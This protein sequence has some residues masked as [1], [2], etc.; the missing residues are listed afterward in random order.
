MVMDHLRYLESQC[1]KWATKSDASML[2]SD[3][4]D[5]DDDKTKGSE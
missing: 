4:E 5:D 3:E 2:T 1:L